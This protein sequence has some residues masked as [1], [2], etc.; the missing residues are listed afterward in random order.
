MT[1]RILVVDDDAHLR[2]VVRYALSREGHDVVEAG[3]G[4]EALDRLARESVDLV[5][6]DVSMPELDGLETC[7]RLRATSSVPVIFLSSR[8]EEIDRIL[9]LEIGGDDY[10]TK[11]FSTRE[12]A[13]RVKVVLRRVRP[14]PAPEP[15][16]AVLVAGPLRL[17]GLAHRVFVGTDEVALTATEFRLLRVLLEHPGRAF[18]R[19]T[20][21]A[22]AYDH[23]HHVSGRTLDSHVRGVRSKLRDAGLEAIETVHGVGYRLVVP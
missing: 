22:R 13:T 7:R 17:D 2:E 15:S 18:T 6:L 12:L 16:D 14:T 3:D 19:D 21:L 5:V 11:P 1:A 4:R 9:G 23:G 10:L 20:L 8:A